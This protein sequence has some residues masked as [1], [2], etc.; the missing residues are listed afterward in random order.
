LF[1]KYIKSVL[2]RVAKHLSYTEDARCLKG[3]PLVNIKSHTEIKSLSKNIRKKLLQVS[4]VAYAARCKTRNPYRFL[5]R[6]MES[7]EEKK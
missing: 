6:K 5:V 4:W 7:Q 3:K 1:I 2:W